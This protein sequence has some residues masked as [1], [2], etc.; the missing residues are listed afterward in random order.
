MHLLFLGPPGSGKGTQ[1]KLLAEKYGLVHVAPGDIFRAEIK[2]KS[3]LGLLVEGILASGALVDDATT[4]RIIE[5]RLRSPEA[6]AGFVLDGFPRNLAQ[7]EA[8]ERMLSSMEES[9]DL[10]LNL[11]VAEELIVERARTRRVCSQCGKPYS[12]AVQPPKVA[13]KCDVCG[14]ELTTRKD[15]AEET[16]R[17]RLQ[18]YHKATK[19]LEDYYGGKGLVAV[20]D[21]EG[22]VAEVNGRIVA[23]LRKRNL[24]K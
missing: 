11:V 7:A 24:A 17:E 6:A 14:G 20:V 16:V 4:V 8:L 23:E 22:E 21:G 10:V 3:E 5:K 19:P 15:D 18:V 9:L 13:G 1:A 12:L 2:A